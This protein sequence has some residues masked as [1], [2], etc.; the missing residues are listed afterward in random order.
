M[1]GAEFLVAGEVLVDSFALSVA[2]G[3]K[4]LAMALSSNHVGDISPSASF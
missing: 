4:L 1:T 3:Y 2:S